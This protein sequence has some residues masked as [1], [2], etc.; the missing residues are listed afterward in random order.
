MKN[1]SFGVLNQTEILDESEKYIEELKINGFTI[2]ENVLSDQELSLARSKIDKVYEMQV[3]EFSQKELESI[4]EL[5]LARL[6]FAYDD[7][8]I[9]FLKNEQ[10]LEIIRQML[11]NY[12]VLHLQNGII[13]MPKQEHHQ[14]SWHRDLPYQDF[15]I[16][17]PL[18]ISVLYCIDNFNEQTGGTVVL[19]FSHK[20]ENMPS[21]EYITK[22][23]KQVIAPQ[24][25]AILFD[26]MIYHKAGYNS[27]D[28]IRRG[29]NHMFTSAILKQQINIP[30]SLSGKFSEDPFLKMLLGYETTIPAN[31]VEW[32]KSRLN[33]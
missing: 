30:S 22:F 6:P 9:S 11:G 16:S 5:Y 23:G 7:Y 1:K 33:K 26:A 13:N 31:V 14:N 28:Q 17:K 8:F 27:S 4:N 19:P 18:A 2:I 12:F 25:S 3:D 15:I 20:V 29:I 10:I 24:G 32:R 21:I